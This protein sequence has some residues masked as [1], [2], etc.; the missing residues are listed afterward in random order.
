[1]CFE[2]KP[3]SMIQHEAVAKASATKTCSVGSQARV[4]L[5]GAPLHHTVTLKG[6][7]WNATA[8]SEQRNTDCKGFFV[9]RE[10]DGKQKINVPESSREDFFPIGPM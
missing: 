7:D 3:K 2:Q 5:A 4:H 10:R 9:E 6:V 8:L 1:M